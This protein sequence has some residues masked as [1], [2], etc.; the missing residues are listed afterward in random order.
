[1]DYGLVLGNVGAWHIHP[2]WHGPARNGG[3][4]LV[5]GGAGSAATPWSARSRDL[6]YEQLTSSLATTP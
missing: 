4:T 5:V 2:S 1:M 3:A 6:T